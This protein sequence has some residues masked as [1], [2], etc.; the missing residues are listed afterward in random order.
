MGAV[1]LICDRELYVGPRFLAGIRVE[2]TRVRLGFDKGAFAFL[3]ALEVATTG[4]WNFNRF[5][6]V[7]VLTR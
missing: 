3:Q 2:E 4:A 1:S 5:L 7:G 6:V